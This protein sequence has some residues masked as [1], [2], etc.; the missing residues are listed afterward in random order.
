MK[1]KMLILFL[2]YGLLA[3]G[4]YASTNRQKSA[5]LIV[6]QD[7]QDFAEGHLNDLASI[8]K[9]QGII[10]W[11]YYYPNA[12]WDNIKEKAKDCSILIYTGHGVANGG[13]NGGFGGM[14]VNDFVTS[15]DIVHDLKFNNH[16]LIIYFNACGSHGTSA[17]D[18]KDIGIDE[19]SKRIT[20]TALPFFKAGAGGYFATSNNGM[21]LIKDFLNGMP[22]QTCFKVQSAGNGQEV[23]KYK[24]ILSDNALNR[25]FI[26]ISGH[27]TDYGKGKYYGTAFV[28]PMQF[29]FESIDQIAK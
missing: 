4:Q 24:P 29:T 27:G 21:E 12:R 3:F 19:A 2:S 28:G 26:G 1:T 10:V 22:L 7:A 18:P 11:K 20:D 23:W 16:P 25:K 15:E 6:G 9:K 8:L 17:G 14:Y 5:V 13:F